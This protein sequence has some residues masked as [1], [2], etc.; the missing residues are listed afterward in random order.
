[1]PKLNLIP[2][3]RFALALWL[4]LTLTFI[5]LR[6][7]PGD[8]ISA[9]LTASGTSQTE[10]ERQ[11]AAFGLDDSLSAQ[12]ARYWLDLLRGDFGVSLVTRERVSS[13]ISAR[14]SPTLSLA[15]ASFGIMSL[16]GLVFGSLAVLP[17][18]LGR[19][20]GESLTAFALAAPS[21]WT[22][23]L[24]IYLFAQRLT[25]LGLPSGGS[26]G[27][28]SLILPALVLGFHSSG[29]LA[30]VVS[31]ALQDN[32]YAPYTQ[33]ARALGLSAWRVYVWALRASLPPILSMMALQAGF[34]LGGTV[35]IEII[36]TRR[37]LGSLLHQAVLNADY[38]VVQALVLLGAL[39]YSLTRALGALAIRQADP[40]LI[41]AA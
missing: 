18:R 36:F 38:P 30:R 25:A 21:Y 4:A 3:I 27:L 5:L 9:S 35:I 15:L 17:N 16:F 34:L 7:I 26:D 24:I 40:R 6:L 19:I 8:A 32:L 12:Y 22:A 10:I 28:K 1:M 23:T 33:T 11:R 29:G 2:L 14:L 37:G 20:L 13:M 41:D 39:A 31:A